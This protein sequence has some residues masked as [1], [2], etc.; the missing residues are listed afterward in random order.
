MILEFL[1]ARFFYNWHNTFPSFLCDVKSDNFTHN[2]ATF[3]KRALLNHAP[4]STQ[5]HPAP[6]IYTQLHPSPP[7]SF[8]RPS[9][10]LQHPQHIRTKMSHV[11]KQFSQIQAKEFNV[12]FLTES[13]CSWYLGGAD[14]GS[15][16][17]FSKFQSQNP[18]LGKFRSKNSKL[19]VSPQNW[20]IWHHDDVDS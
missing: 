7:S 5:L 17:R 6:S 19:S 9:S 2:G 3:F 16:L 10:F 20:H 11:I 15:R 4:S 12:V 8:Q 14:P 1:F 13:W 18:F